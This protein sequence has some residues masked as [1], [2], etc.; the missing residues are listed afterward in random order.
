MQ[1]NFLAAPR[2]PA[3]GALFQR[4]AP[5]APPR[6]CQP[7]RATA[8]TRSLQVGWRAA[9]PARLLHRLT[10]QL[11]PA[12]YSVALLCV[13]ANIPRRRV[14]AARRRCIRS[15]TPPRSQGQTL[16]PSET[17]RC[18]SVL[19]YRD[20]GATQTR[21]RKQANVAV[22]WSHAQILWHP[23]DASDA[24]LVHC[25]L[26]PLTPRSLPTAPPFLL[27][28]APGPPWIPPAIGCITMYFFFANK[29]RQTNFSPTK[30]IEAGLCRNFLWNPLT[31]TS[32]INSKFL[33]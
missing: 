31:L 21:T 30:F 7:W 8:S 29:I 28:T 22:F 3:W 16:N 25:P 2:A 13:Q 15:A 26:N 33:S 9:H 24:S 18:F 19:L 20:I 4:P 11:E 32:K 10:S 6:P 5:P 23:T 27:P 12:A 1:F 17:I 14:A